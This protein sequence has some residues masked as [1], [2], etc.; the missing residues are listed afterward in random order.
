MVYYFILYNQNLIILLSFIYHYQLSSILFALFR[1]YS[2]EIMLFSI[3]QIIRNDFKT[4]FVY[5]TF[6]LR[7]LQ[8]ATNLTDLMFHGRWYV[9]AL[10]RSL[11]SPPW[12][13]SLTS[14]QQ[15]PLTLANRIPLIFTFFLIFVFPVLRIRLWSFLELISIFPLFQGD[16]R[17]THPLQSENYIWYS[18]EVC[19]K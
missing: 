16:N 8:H 7:Y 5:A 17:V 1:L 10:T 19:N 4:T 18:L 2:E 11:V 6:A 9:C 3:W 12:K 13:Y 15:F 14:Q